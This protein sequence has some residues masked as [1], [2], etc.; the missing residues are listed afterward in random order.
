MNERKPPAMVSVFDGRE[1]IGFVITRRHGFEAYTADER[2]LGIFPTMQ[3][4]ADAV[5]N[6]KGPASGKKRRPSSDKSV[7]R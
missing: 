3:D 2:S 5:S 7:T 1:C 6:A 4:A